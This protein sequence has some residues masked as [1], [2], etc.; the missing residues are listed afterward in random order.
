VIERTYD[1]E[2]VEIVDEACEVLGA[3]VKERRAKPKP[4]PYV[5]IDTREQRPLR[6][7]PE[8]GVD[9]G[10]ASLPTGDYSVRG[11]THLIAL[12]RKSVADLIGTLTKGRERFEA[13]LDLLTQFRW[14]AILVEGSRG[15]VEA[16]I[17]RSLAT[18]QSIMGSLRAIWMRWNVP[19]FW[20]DSPEGCAREVAWFARRLETKHA[21]LKETG[22]DAKPA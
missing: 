4:R 18:P 11:F 3:V 5:L 7:A 15:D 9:C 2:G 21:D 6:F 22:E 19:T 17:Y 16:G 1:H 8:L 10:V 14:K 13:E 20:L 12:E